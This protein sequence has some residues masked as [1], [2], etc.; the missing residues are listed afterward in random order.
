MHTVKFFQ[1]HT[2]KPI[3][4]VNYWLNQALWQRDTSAYSTPSKF[5]VG[6]FQRDTEAD[7]KPKLEKGPDNFL[8]CV[9]L[10]HKDYKDKLR[11]LLAGTRRQWLVEQLSSLG[12]D[13]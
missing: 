8:A 9:K 7:G 11:V 12:I 2:N 13:F 10:L 5:I 1:Q 3:H 4:L 6:S